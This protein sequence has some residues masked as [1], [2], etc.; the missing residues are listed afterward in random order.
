MISII[1][2][3]VIIFVIYSS[4][5]LSNYVMTMIIRIIVIINS[6]GRPSLEL[7]LNAQQLE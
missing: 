6:I 1:L 2:A 3:V 4:H 5:I 7:I